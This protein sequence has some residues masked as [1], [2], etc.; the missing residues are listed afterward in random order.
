MKNILLILLLFT[1]FACTRPVDTKSETAVILVDSLALIEDHLQWAIDSQFIAGGVALIAKDNKIVYQKAI[2]YADREKTEPL[3]TDHIFRMASMTKP[4]VSVAVMQLVEQGKINTTDPI[5]KYIPEFKNPQ[6]LEN[7]NPD[8]STYTTRP[9]VR[10]I[11]IHHLLTH[12]SGLGYG[13]FDPMVG[14]VYAP[15]GITEAWTKDSVRLKTNVPK[16]GKLPLLHDPGTKFTYGVS[17]DVLGYVVEVVSGMPLDQYLQENIFSPLNMMDT[18]FYLPVEKAERL[19]D[20][21]FT[22]DFDPT[23]FPEINREDYP[24]QGFKTY[25]SGG[26]GLSS[27]ATDYL[28]FAS[29]ILNHG[30][31][32][33]NRILKEETI[34]LMMTNQIDSLYIGENTQFGYG[35]SV[36]TGDG[37]LGQKKGRFGWDGFW[38]TRFWVDPERNMVCIVLTNAIYA[39]KWDQFFNRYEEIVNHAV[40]E[41]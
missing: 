40:I 18:Y 30:E 28:K 9:A 31:G 4:I 5:S 16:M 35:G 37:V 33:G 29:A 20:V 2:G 6:V 23:G 15:F 27:T 12:T 10:E 39:T 32:N 25:F 22:K 11:T 34:K 38:Q 21:W 36:H 7:F 17:I 8:N 24:V 19:V 13:S 3:T 1:T 14:A 26:G 41:E